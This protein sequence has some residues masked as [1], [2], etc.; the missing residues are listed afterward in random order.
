MPIRV[1]DSVPDIRVKM[2]AQGQI[3]NVSMAGLCAKGISVIFALPGA[4]TPQCSARHLPGFLE[5]ADDF[6]AKGVDR[7]ACIAVNDVF[8]MDAWARANRVDGRILMLADGNGEFTRACGLETDARPYGM[9]LRSQRYAM[10]VSDGRVAQLYVDE[11]G[12]FEVSAAAYVL[13]KL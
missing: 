9:G 5:H 2:M 13:G 1:S 7:I 12:A 10:V 8:V 11:P 3:E 6:K 4:F